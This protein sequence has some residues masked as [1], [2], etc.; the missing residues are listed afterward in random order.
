MNRASMHGD[1]L[2]SLELVIERLMA[3]CFGNQFVI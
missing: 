3:C 2:Q 1:I